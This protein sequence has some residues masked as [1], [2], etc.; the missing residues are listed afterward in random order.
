MDTQQTSGNTAKS[1]ANTRGP[2]TMA[3]KVA[4]IRACESMKPDNERI[5]CDPYAIHFLDPGTRQAL[6]QNAPEF[7][8]ILEQIENQ[9]P[10]ISGAIVAR[11]RCFDEIALQSANA[12]YGQIVILGAGYDSR[13]YRMDALKTLRV[14][15]VDHPDTIRV[16]METIKKIF[17]T[18]P[19]QVTYVP[20][21]LEDCGLERI[22]ADSGYD[23]SKRTLFLMEGLV[24]YLSPES[25]DR[26]LSFIVNNSPAGSS[27]LFDYC[28][29]DDGTGSGA[30]WNSVRSASAFAGRQGEPLRS[31]VKGS[32]R[33]FMAKRGFA[34]IRNI[35]GSDLREA[36]FTGKNSGRTISE[37]YSIASASVDTQTC[38]MR[39]NP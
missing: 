36:Y 23:P 12:G 14:F 34:E 8:Y 25:V 13:S 22:L 1:N 27:V 37:L 5:C 7:R 11:V 10:G 35:T 24:M 9:L 15:E 31:C 29:D 39:K 16:K 18:L 26:V 32:I 6:L 38:T 17:G 19:P 28:P 3:G 30:G 33:E 2:S 21:N 4:V 20:A